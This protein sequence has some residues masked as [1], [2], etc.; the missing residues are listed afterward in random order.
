MP[1]LPA[2]PAPDRTSIDRRKFFGV[3]AGAAAASALLNST[4]AR[5]DA[6]V[7]TGRHRHRRVRFGVNYVPSENWW[8]SWSDWDRRSIAADLDDI[9]S[10]GMDHIRI[11]LIWSELQP[12]ATY[13]RGELLDR[14]EEL[15]DLADRRHLDV[16]V[17]VFNGAVSG[18]LFVP[19]FLIS[20]SDGTIRNVLTDPTVIEREQWLLG[21]IAERIGRHRRFM[22]FDLSNEIHWFAKPLGMAVTQAQG[23][24]W[25][26]ALFDTCEKVAPGKIH[27]SGIDHWPWQNNDFWTRQG[28]GTAGTMTANHTWAGWTQV[29]QR[30]GSLSTSSTHYS[31]FFVELIQ[32]FHAD[33]KR[34]IWIEE[35]GVSTVWMDAA[36]IPTW[37]ERSIRAMAD[38]TGLFGI[39]WW[40]SHDLNPKLTGYVDLEY[41]LGLFT[42]D[43]KLKPI[44]R[45]IRKLIAEYDAR[46]PSPSPRATALVLPDDMIPVADFT[47]FFDPF[48]KLVDRGERPAVVLQSRTTDTAYLA[49]RGITHLVT[50]RDV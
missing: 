1:E 30:Y 48:M 37:T 28:L 2:T 13:V 41:D 31:E 23:D 11:M 26:T 14:L 50:P 35:T 20:N 6:A 7:P 15:L 24:A 38:C 12:N 33:L 10:L 46:P 36:D 22:G 27:V 3:T 18:V 49:S 40:D 25:H 21:Q 44:G 43:R 47:A 17:T 39:T 16:E 42:N 5:A 4:A 19:P 9:A 8:F 45:T 34:Q 32:A 29:I